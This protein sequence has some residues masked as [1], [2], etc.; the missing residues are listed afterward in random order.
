MA[1]AMRDEKVRE[2][3]R[4]K[5][6]LPH[7][8]PL[9]SYVTQLRKRT[10]FEVPDF[11]PDDGGIGAE[12][13]FVFEKPGP[14]ASGSGFIS[15]D[16]DDPTAEAT[17]RFFAEAGIN[18]KRIAVWNAVPG[19]NGTRKITRLEL[20]SGRDELLK[21]IA[22][23]PKIRSIVLVGRKS[24]RLAKALEARNFKVFTSTHPSP[25][26]R[27]TNLEQWAAIP[28]QWRLAYRETCIDE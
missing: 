17:F 1:R 8:A 16:N 12:I 4:K 15:C 9:S 11:D 20:S 18:R 5:L 7:V 13:L 2:Q 24:Q 22:L 10:G 6:S 23:F 25:I 14:M 21:V 19:W 3:R 28:E 26:V 27:A